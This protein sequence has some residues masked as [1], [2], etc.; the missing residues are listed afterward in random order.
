MFSR[1][2]NTRNAQA[3]LDCGSLMGKHLGRRIWRNEYEVEHEKARKADSISLANR[4][5]ALARVGRGPDPYRKGIPE[6]CR[7][8]NS[9]GTAR[10][11]S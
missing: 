11:S 1:R 5:G 10:D 7:P 4:G 6:S 2:Q 8:E 3:R 9:L